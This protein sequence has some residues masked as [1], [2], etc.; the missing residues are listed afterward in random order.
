MTG[1]TGHHVSVEC[2]RRLGTLLTLSQQR[3]VPDAPHAFHFYRLEY[4]ERLFQLGGLRCTDQRVRL[5]SYVEGSIDSLQL[6]CV[7][8]QPSGFIDIVA[9][10]IHS[11]CI[12]EYCRTGPR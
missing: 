5:P 9:G 6:G 12:C 1:R 2:L 3:N 8:D 10:S 11:I 7:S 4:G